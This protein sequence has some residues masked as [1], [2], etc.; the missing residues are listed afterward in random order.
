LPQWMVGRAPSSKLMPETFSMEGFVLAGG[1]STR[2]GRDKALLELGGVPMA[3]RLADLLL[4]LA[5]QVSLIGPPQQFVEIPIRVLADDEPGL[6]PL[7]GIATALH[8]S[9]QA[10]AMVLGCDL[11]FLSRAWLAYLKQRAAASRADALLPHNE[12]GQAEPL[13]AM[14]RARA[15]SAIQG[16]L[17]RGVRKV[18]DGLAGLNVEIIPPTEWKEFDSGGLLFK[19]MNTPEDYEQARAVFA[20]G[21]AEIWLAG[22]AQK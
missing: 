7:G 14:Y 10:W 11:P 6:G 2:M 18:T 9:R 22:S 17:G 1:S 4:P 16:A 3:A 8:H 21:S 5:E 13:C 20:R 19:N 15:H 12:A